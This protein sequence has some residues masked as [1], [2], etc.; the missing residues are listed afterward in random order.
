MTIN[1]MAR[2]AM[3]PIG[4]TDRNRSSSASLQAW[5]PAEQWI[6][7]TPS[8]GL[9]VARSVLIA[10][11][12]NAFKYLTNLSAAPGVAE[13][14]IWLASISDFLIFLKGNSPTFSQ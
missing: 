14:F 6:F 1:S 2:R 7:D 13:R 4:Y 5:N 8:A 12:N 10:Q 9:K 11:L 3:L